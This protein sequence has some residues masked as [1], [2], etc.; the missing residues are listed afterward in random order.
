VFF[1]LAYR[2][3]NRFVL[4]LALSTL[5]G[6]FGLRLSQFPEIGPASRRASAL[7][8]GVLVAMAGG[9]LYRA[10][11]KKHFLDAYLHVAANVLFVTLLSAQFDRSAHALYLVALL[12]LAAVAI[13]AG[14]RVTRFAFVV[15]GVLYGYAGV[16]ARVVDGI[17]A[18]T[19][20]LAYVVVSGTIVIVAL[21]V[22]ARQFG[23]EE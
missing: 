19:D 9:G 11:I 8:Y 1:L 23:R 20:A 7:T 14:I 15:Y 18:F 3:D 21:V 22:L 13:A 2:F 16:S 12:G 10:G 6:W 4:S 17:N 5:A